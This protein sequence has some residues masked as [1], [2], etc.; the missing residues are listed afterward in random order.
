[1]SEDLAFAL[2]RS[3][4]ASEFLTWIW[5]RCEVEGGTFDLPSGGLSLAVEDSLTLVGWEDDAVKAAL[6][7]GTPTRRPE[8]ANALA[9]G[10]LLKKSRFVAARAGREWLF[11][12]DAADLDLK[13]VKVVEADPEEDPE[14]A[15]ADKLA[16]GEELRLAIDELYEH[17]LGVRLDEEW[18]L[19]ATRLRDWVRDKAVQ[20]KAAIGVG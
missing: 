14:D 5:F 12:L 15:L 8:A 16:A 4:L 1:M 6:K 3:F 9:S 19:E 2:E 17:F 10:L 7:G 20:A 13:G 18:T 11:T